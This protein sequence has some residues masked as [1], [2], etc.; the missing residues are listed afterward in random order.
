MNTTDLR[1]VLVELDEDVEYHERGAELSRIEEGVMAHSGMAQ[2]ARLARYRVTRHLDG[3]EAAVEYIT[4]GVSRTAGLCAVSPSICDVEASA[5][6]RACAERDW[7]ARYLAVMTGS[8]VAQV[9]ADT[10]AAM[11]IRESGTTAD[12]QEAGR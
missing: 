10:H 4:S 1:T 2:G 7:L 8:T 5:L 6:E 9:L 11:A 3:E 12:G